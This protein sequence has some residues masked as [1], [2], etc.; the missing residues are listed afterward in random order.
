MATHKSD[1]DLS[2]YIP[3]LERARAMFKEGM[4]GEQQVITERMGIM[5]HCTGDDHPSPR[6]PNQPPQ[7]DQNLTAK[8][9][10]LRSP[11]LASP[12]S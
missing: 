6:A 4:M 7:R 5:E 12:L 10:P 1:V 9:N 3:D 2:I 11:L 8:L